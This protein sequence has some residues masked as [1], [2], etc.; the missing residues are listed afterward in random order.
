MSVEPE[1]PM[2]AAEKLLEASYQLEKLLD[3][4]L[5]YKVKAIQ[6]G[7]SE[8]VAE[9]MALQLHVKLVENAF[10]PTRREKR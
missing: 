8:L 3:V 10:K 4:A 9:N 5:A 7:F 1:D 2:A 6:R